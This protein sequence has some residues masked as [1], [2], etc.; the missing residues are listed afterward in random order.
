MGSCAQVTSCLRGDKQFLIAD[1]PRNANF[2]VYRRV[3]ERLDP[4]SSSSSS[5]GAR[6][7]EELG[8][9]LIPQPG[10]V[11]AAQE[12]ARDKARE[13]EQEKKRARFHEM[14]GDL[15]DLEE[16]DAGSIDLDDEESLAREKAREQEEEEEERA[17]PIRVSGDL[18][19]LEEAS[20]GYV[21]LDY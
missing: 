15:P 20:A 10:D 8:K 19:D 17:G 7:L 2:A 4:S 12:L 21:D 13:Q 3:V 6:I 14:C 9:Q 16:A 18:P 1:D 5:D 11:E